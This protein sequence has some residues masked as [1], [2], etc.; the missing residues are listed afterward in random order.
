MMMMI[1]VNTR[2]LQFA[3]PTYHV[4]GYTV[5]IKRAMKWKVSYVLAGTFLVV[6]SCLCN[7]DAIFFVIK[8][9][10]LCYSIELVD[11]AV[12]CKF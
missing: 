2:L 10:F 4:S 1:L 5:H 7:V 6:S 12:Y 9:L 3:K 11:L 8:L